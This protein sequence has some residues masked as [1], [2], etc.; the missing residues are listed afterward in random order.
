MTRLGRAIEITGFGNGRGQ[1]SF[2][3]FVT[4]TALQFFGVALF[5]IIVELRQIPPWYVWSFGFG[6]VGAGFGLKGYLGA[7]ARRT[8]S[9]TANNITSTTVNAAD[10]IR[11]ASDAI[12]KRRDAAA[13]IDPT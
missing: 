6:V 4:F 8:E 7:A 1:I 9:A 11:A 12:A 5:A 10:V 2:N 3:K 13:G